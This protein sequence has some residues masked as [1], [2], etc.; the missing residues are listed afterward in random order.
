MKYF[1]EK[2]KDWVNAG[3]RINCSH[4]MFSTATLF[5]N[6]S[7][8]LLIIQERFNE[9]TKTRWWSSIEPWIA[10]DIYLSDGFDDIF[11]K[12]AGEQNDDGM[13]P[14]IKLRKIMWELRMKPLKKEFW[15]EF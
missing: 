5:Q 6:G 10:G 7:K 11:E 13:F 3:R 1:Y 9:N 8:G 4:P 2:P 12:Y 15:E 14:Y